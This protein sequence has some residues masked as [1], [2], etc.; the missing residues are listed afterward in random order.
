MNDILKGYCECGCGDLTNIYRGKFRRFIKGHQARG[1]NNSRFGITLDDALKK[2]ISDV[3][4]KCG[5]NVEI[6]WEHDIKDCLDKV[7]K[8]LC[9][10]YNIQN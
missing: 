6:I 5:F 7:I 9:Q 1:E 4:T 2:K 10:K 8:S 3:R